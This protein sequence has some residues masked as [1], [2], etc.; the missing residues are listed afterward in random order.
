MYVQSPDFQTLLPNLSLSGQEFY[1]NKERG[2][3]N[4]LPPPSNG[5]RICAADAPLGPSGSGL[6]HVHVWLWSPFFRR[7]YRVA[8]VKLQFFS[9]QV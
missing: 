2:V 9:G 7:R 4:P 6:P 3:V 1:Q 5:P 8:E